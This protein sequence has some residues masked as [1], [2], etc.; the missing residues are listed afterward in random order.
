MS[1]KI[2]LMKKPEWLSKRRIL[3]AGA[4]LFLAGP[5]VATVVGNKDHP[6]SKSLETENPPL[7]INSYEHSL[8]TRVLDGQITMNDGTLAKFRTFNDKNERTK[9]LVDTQ[10][11]LEPGVRLDTYQ[12]HSASGDA[13][14]NILYAGSIGLLNSLRGDI[15]QRYCQSGQITPENRLVYSEDLQEEVYDL[16]DENTG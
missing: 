10:S 5:P 7:D 4:V 15:R 11:C 13:F 16:F 6:G 3:A 9:P 14:I 12:N 1:A 2:W 8:F